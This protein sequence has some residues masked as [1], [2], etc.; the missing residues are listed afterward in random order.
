MYTTTHWQR[1]G[2]VADLYGCAVMIQWL[3]G[4]FRGTRRGNNKWSYKC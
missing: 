4:N 3:C 1:E 2:G